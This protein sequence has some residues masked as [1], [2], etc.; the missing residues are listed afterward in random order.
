M[1]RNFPTTKFRSDLGESM[2]EKK[3][4]KCGIVQ[5]ISEFYKHSEMGDGHLNKCKTCTKLDVKKRYV[6]KIDRIRDYE[7]RRLK[8][9]GRKAKV[10]EYQRRRRHKHP[11]KNLARQR[12]HYALRTGKITRCPCQLCGGARAEAHHVD[13]SRPFDVRWLCFKCHRTYAHG[14]KVA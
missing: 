12:L 10:L 5:P 11:E 7:K 13:Y 6:M 4:F 14:Q 8:T 3:C 2:H 9:P 1:R